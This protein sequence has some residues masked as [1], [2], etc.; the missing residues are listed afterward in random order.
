MRPRNQKGTHFLLQAKARTISIPDLFTLSDEEVWEAFKYYRWQDTN[1]EAICPHCG[2]TD[3]HFMKG[4]KRWK[5]RGCW[6]QFSVTSKTTFAYHKNPLRIYLLAIL[7]YANAVK[8]VSALQL[9]RDA[10]TGY[11]T[12]FVMA[13][14]I[15]DALLQ[16][17]E[18]IMMKGIVEVDGCYINKHIRP[19]NKKAD[20]IDR[21]K[22]ENRNSRCIL[23]FAER[24]DGTGR[25][26]VGSKA[27]YTA[28]Y[29]NENGVDVLEACEKK[30]QKG[31]LIHADESRAYDD[32]HGFF[33]MK[34]VNHSKEYKS[35]DGACNNIVESFFSRFRRL[36]YGQHHMFAPKYAANYA[37]EA[38][39]RE[40]NRRMSNGEMV[41]DIL[42]RCLNTPTSPEWCG[43][44][45]GNHR[46]GERLGVA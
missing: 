19:K 40:T 31:T 24:S 27:V 23:A 33:L 37:N 44:W 3:V 46:I 25:N 34:R 38:A 26:P 8:G 11:Q 35:D 15:R 21:R 6:Q 36:E 39:Y 2:C 16:T 32:L 13:H 9:M 12:M 4:Y 41:Q 10:G 5:C 1:G 45:Q 17:R 7:L 28:I 22:A 29:R 14:K 30:V 42:H 18:E 20:R 43:Y